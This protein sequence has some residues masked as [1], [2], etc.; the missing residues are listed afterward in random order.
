MTFSQALFETWS[1]T[2]VVYVDAFQTI[3][4]QLAAHIP[5]D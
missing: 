2:Y 1:F 5:G 3:V 4:E